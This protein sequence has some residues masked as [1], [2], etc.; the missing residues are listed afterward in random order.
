MM[1][2]GSY[3]LSKED[4]KIYQSRDTSFDFS[5][6]RYMYFFFFHQKPANFAISRNADIGRI[7][8]HNL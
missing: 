8:I 3:T 7:L 4:A 5:L 1:K 2:L 6:H